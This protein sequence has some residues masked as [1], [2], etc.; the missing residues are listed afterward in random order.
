MNAHST[1]FVGTVYQSLFYKAPI[2]LLIGNLPFGPDFKNKRHEYEYLNYYIVPKLDNNYGGVLF[3]SKFLDNYVA[4]KEPLTTWSSMYPVFE[5][6]YEKYYLNPFVNDVN[7]ACSWIPE[8]KLTRSNL[9]PEKQET[10]GSVYYSNQAYFNFEK[11]RYELGLGENVWNLRGTYH[12]LH[13]K[14]LANGYS[15]GSEGKMN[16]EMGIDFDD[17][18]N[19]KLDTLSNSGIRIGYAWSIS[20]I[21]IDFEK[22]NNR[23]NLD[24]SMTAEVINENIS[25]SSHAQLKYAVTAEGTDYYNFYERLDLIPDL[26]HEDAPEKF[27][28]MCGVYENVQCTHQFVIGS[29][30]IGNTDHKDD[31]GYFV[32]INSFVSQNSAISYGTRTRFFRKNSSH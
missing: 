22:V 31:L 11:N 23:D 21:G 10:Q 9:F 27:D 25:K 28:K 12:H 26:D 16:Y 6:N 13:N 7:G 30:V 5:I 19:K 14:N 24:I 17:V 32:G 8:A 18:R 1:N 15:F 4:L 2:P 20:G 3:Y 29:I